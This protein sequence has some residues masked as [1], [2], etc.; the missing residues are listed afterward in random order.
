M[1]T[2]RVPISTRATRQQIRLIDNLDSGQVDNI[3]DIPRLSTNEKAGVRGV[4][5]E[6]GRIVDTI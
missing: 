1:W 5:A 2:H 3:S 6:N 4:V